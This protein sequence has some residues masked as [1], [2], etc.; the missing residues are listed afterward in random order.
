MNSSW[1]AL[2]GFST[3]LREGIT[4][5]QIE[6]ALSELSKMRATQTSENFLLQIW[7]DKFGK[8]LSDLKKKKDNNRMVI[9][10][11]N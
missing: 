10:L 4:E 1:E 6:T 5:Q 2:F 11:L 3:T 9:Y 8:W 7:E